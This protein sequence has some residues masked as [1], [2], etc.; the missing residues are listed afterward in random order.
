[1]KHAKRM[2]LVPEDVLVR[3]EKKQKLETSP[4]TAHMIQQDTEM[5]DILDRQDLPDD[6]KQ[7]A[8]YANLE[9]YLNLGQQKYSQI[10]TVQLASKKD[11]ENIKENVEM[12]EAIHLSDSVILDNIPKT[13]RNRA[14]A[15]LNRLKT[16]PDVILWDKTGQVNVDGVKISHSNISDLFG[17]AVRARKSFNPIGS[18]EFFRGLS[19]MNMPKDLVRNEG[20]WKQVQMDS[21]SEEEEV[22]YRSPL[23]LGKTSKPKPTLKA[24]WYK[25]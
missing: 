7:K 11:D 3:Y 6:Q 22:L 13:M 8:Y 9:R 19:K 5:S 12:P 2:V 16:R 20:R 4:F 24:A 14:T 10:P 1:M 21:P 15:I 25:Y 23:K 17:D 18:K